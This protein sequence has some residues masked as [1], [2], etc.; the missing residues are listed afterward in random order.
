MR[1]M[2][3]RTS[4]TSTSGVVLISVIGLSLPSSFGDPMFIDM[5]VLPFLGQQPSA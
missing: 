3:S 1:K 5:V 4:M 2:M